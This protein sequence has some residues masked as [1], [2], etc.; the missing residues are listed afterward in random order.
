MEERRRVGLF[1][2]YLNAIER[3]GNRLPHPIFL[4]VILSAVIVAVSAV[5]AAFGVSATGELIADGELKVTTITAVSLLN[6]EG[7]AYIFS[8][9]VENF[10]TYAPLGMVLVAMLGVGVAEESGMIDALLKQFIRITPAKLLTPVIVFLGVMSNIASDAGYVILIPLGAMVFRACGR[11][12]IA[13]LAAAFAGV[14]G[15]FSA[16]LLIGTLDPMLAGISQTAVSIIDPNYEVAVLGNYWFLAASTFLITLLGTTLTDNFVEPRLGAYD[17]TALEEDHHL[18]VVHEKEREGLKRA[19]IAALLYIVLL[20][21]CCIPRNSFFRS[22][23]GTLF[24][25]NASPFIDGLMVLVAL[26]FFI[27]GVVYGLH[28]GT[29]RNDKDVANAMSKAMSGMGSFLALAFV[30]AQC[31]NY[32]G[33]TKLGS[34]LALSGASFLKEIHIGLIP[35]L[36]LF[37]PFSAFVNLFM[38]SA[39]A[40]WTIL[41]PV[42]VPMFMLLGYSPELCQLAYRIGDSATNLITP[43]MTY[44]AVIITFA[45]RYDKKSGVGTLI[46]TMLPYSMCFLLFWTIMLVVWISIGLPIG[47]QTGLFYPAV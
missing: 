13:G 26:L 11:H 5:C 1:E 39:S 34:I 12:P 14:S 16:N 2:R 45:Q 33:Y 9:A 47:I 42:F 20:V 30:S 38:G 21:A 7:F 3:A 28:V 46:A 18:T 8:S 19:G 4:F 22:V 37:I 44:Y 41:A 6:R 29:F 43:L 10:V 35:L 36:L 15:G 23:D 27:P 25:H 17:G 40:K 24:G 32:F 31:V